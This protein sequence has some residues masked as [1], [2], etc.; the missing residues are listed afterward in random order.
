L[1]VDASRARDEAKMADAGT[2]GLAAETQK[3][4]DAVLAAHRQ[5]VRWEGRS[6][7]Q[8]PYAELA[9]AY[10][11]VASLVDVWLE[12]KKKQKAAQVAAEGKRA[13][14]T[15]LEFQIQTLRN[16][17]A[18]HE[19]TSEKEQGDCQHRLREMGER[20]DALETELLELATRF[21]S[22]L[23]TRP[24]LGSLFTELE[25]VAA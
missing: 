19:E 24:E 16:A 4:A 20:A 21:C 10:R 11:K 9:Q 15:D 25:G 5:I 13:E 1:G 22:P 3:C 7:F 14:V 8:E 12:A 23:R 17:L 18:K 2:G 6:A